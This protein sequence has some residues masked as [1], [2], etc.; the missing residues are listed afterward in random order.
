MIGLAPAMKIGV[1]L[2]RLC[3]MLAVFF[4]SLGVWMAIVGDHNG[5]AGNSIAFDSQ[6]RDF[7]Y[8]SVNQKIVVS[9]F[10]ANQSAT[11]VMIL[12]SSESCNEGGCIASETQLPIKIE[13]GMSVKLAV[14]CMPSRPGRYQG[15]LSIY[16]NSPGQSELVLTVVGEVAP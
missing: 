10:V 13:A 8:G 4:G 7:G 12:G 3:I 2:S 9:F 16:T 14:Y 11:P 6:T 5:S 15:A 1:L